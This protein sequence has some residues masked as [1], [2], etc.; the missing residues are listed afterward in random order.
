M[1]AL[2]IARVSGLLP[3]CCLSLAF[4]LASA[5]VVHVTPP[6]RTLYTTPKEKNYSVKVRLTSLDWRRAFLSKLDPR[7]K[8]T[9]GTPIHSWWRE[10]NLLT[11]SRKCPLLVSDTFRH[12]VTV[13]GS[14]K[15]G[16]WALITSCLFNN[17]NEWCVSLLVG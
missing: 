11:D 9:S 14:E 2:M 4:S 1:I 10:A 16:M 5:T 15:W 6:R 13:T 3:A 7:F 17:N 8:R 12:A